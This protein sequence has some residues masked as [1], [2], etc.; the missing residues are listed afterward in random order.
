MR[1]FSDNVIIRKFAQEILLVP[2]PHAVSQPQPV[3]KEETW[4]STQ[5][6]ILPASI[7]EEPFQ[8][9]MEEDKK[10]DYIVVNEGGDMSPKSSC[11]SLD[12]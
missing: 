6:P 2:I 4:V 3:S 10:V 12:L 7:H 1:Q 5:T 9:L 11:P 8:D